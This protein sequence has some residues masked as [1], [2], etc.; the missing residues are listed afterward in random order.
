[1]FVCILTGLIKYAQIQF[2][3]IYNNIDMKPFHI[4]WAANDATYFYANHHL[5]YEHYVLVYGAVHAS[6]DSA[7]LR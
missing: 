2:Y 5:I 1:M 3:T 4:N 6:L 7:Q